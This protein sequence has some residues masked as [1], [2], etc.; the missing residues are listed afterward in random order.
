MLANLRADS[1]VVVVVCD[2]S[3]RP[4]APTQLQIYGE[5]CS[6]TNFVAQLLRRNFP[7]LSLTDRYG[8]KHG[9]VRRLE[10]AAPDCLFVVVTRDPLDWIRSLHQKPWHAAAPLRDVTLAEFMR[11]PW[12]C[13]WGR[14]MQLL[15]DD[16]RLG[17]E[18]M[19]ERDPET[20]ER[21]ANVM[22]LRASKLRNWFALPERVQHYLAVRYEDAAADPRRLVREVAQRFGMR[23]WPWLRSVKT[24]K[25]GRERFVKKQ[26]EPIPSADRDWIVSQLDLPLERA[27]GYEPVQ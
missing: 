22:K 26:Y 4:P 15:A 21:F 10:D 24:F 3:M 11:Q 18:M 19:H 27:A 6:G 25:G 13:E 16:A 9:F 23:R 20:G 17:T 14:D 1:R 7:R 12:W 5:R 2:L 8:W